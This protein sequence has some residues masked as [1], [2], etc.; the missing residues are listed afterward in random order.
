MTKFATS[1]NETTW[2]SRLLRRLAA[3]DINTV[4]AHYM[5]EAGPAIATGFIDALERGLA[6]IGRHP[7]S[8]SLRFAYELDIPELRAWPLTRYPYVV[9]YV[10]HESRVD[11][12]RVLH[13]RRDIPTA[14]VHE[15][16]E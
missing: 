10:E 12:W 6:H 7:H 8:G 15:P 3:D 2:P 14:L 9:F 5:A 4:L 16:E 11:D 1:C 13:T